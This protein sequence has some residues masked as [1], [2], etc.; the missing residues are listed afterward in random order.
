M[1]ERLLKENFEIPCW[2]FNICFFLSE[3]GLVIISAFRRPVRNVFHLHPLI[4]RPLP[5]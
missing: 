2:L 5:E 4:A 3:M 1:F